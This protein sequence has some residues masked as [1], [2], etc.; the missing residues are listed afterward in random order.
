M[1]GIIRKH[2]GP[3]NVMKETIHGGVYHFDKLLAIRPLRGNVPKAQFREW[4]RRLVYLIRIRLGDI[5]TEAFSVY[6]NLP[7]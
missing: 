4:W 2:E 5:V 6:T 7:L 1:T 3:V